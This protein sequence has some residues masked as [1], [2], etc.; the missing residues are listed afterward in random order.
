MG[1]ANAV[2]LMSGSVTNTPGLGAAKSSL[3]EIELQFAGKQFADPAVAYAITYPM[4]VLGVISVIILT[5][6]IFKVNIKEELAKVQNK[7]G[8]DTS[9]LVRKNVVSPTQK[10]LKKHISHY[11]RF[12]S[13]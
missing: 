1:I 4:G 6:V 10:Y 9:G 13:Q 12:Q 11:E 2:G 5:K 7:S 3:H 8:Q